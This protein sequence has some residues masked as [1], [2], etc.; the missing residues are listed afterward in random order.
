MIH[1][2]LWKGNILTTLGARKGVACPLG[3]SVDALFTVVVATR[4]DLGLLIMF[5]ADRTGN[6]LLQFLQTSLSGIRH[7]IEIFGINY[8]AVELLQ[9][10]SARANLYACA[11]NHTHW[12]GCEDCE[13]MA[14]LTV[15]EDTEP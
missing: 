15:L 2:A 8:T 6:L 12:L 5:M 13:L 9:V 14:V 4:E 7:E 11:I 1:P 3:Q 10:E